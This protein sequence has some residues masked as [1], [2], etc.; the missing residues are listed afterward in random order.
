MSDM[1]DIT[2]TPAPTPTVEEITEIVAAQMNSVQGRLD[3]LVRDRLEVNDA[4]REARAQLKD[5]QRSYKA[6]KR[7]TK[8]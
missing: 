7:P 6:L 1:T 4:I 3:D 8:K 5:L 2:T